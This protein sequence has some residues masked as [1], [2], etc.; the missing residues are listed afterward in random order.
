MSVPKIIKI[1]RCYSVLLVFIDPV[2]CQLDP[3]ALKQRDLKRRSIVK[4]PYVLYVTIICVLSLIVVYCIKQD[5]TV[6]VGALFI[7]G[8]HVKCISIY[9]VPLKS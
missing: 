9:L 3:F 4:F 8:D 7:L 6:L 2:S 1:H 5:T